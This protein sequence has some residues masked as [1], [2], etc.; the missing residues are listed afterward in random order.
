MRQYAVSP[1]CGFLTDALESERQTACGS[2]ETFCRAYVVCGTCEGAGV[3]ECVIRVRCE[4]LDETG[5]H[6]TSQLVAAL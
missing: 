1:M 4:R 6:L 3:Y 5:I 2:T